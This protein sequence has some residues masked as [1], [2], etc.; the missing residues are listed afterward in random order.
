MGFRIVRVQGY[1]VYRTDL[2]TLG[3][4]EMAHAFGTTI[5]VNFINDIT[6]EDGVI[7]ALGFTDVA[8]DTLISNDQ[9]HRAVIN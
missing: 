8:V 1:A 2:L 7:R 6:L 3:L 9:G 4:F 5:G